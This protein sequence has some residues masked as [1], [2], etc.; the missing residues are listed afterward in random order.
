MNK[1]E[2]RVINAFINC[3]KNG[4]FT[5]DYACT[6]IEDSNKYG[7]LT[8]AAKEVFYA[9]VEKVDEAPETEEIEDTVGEFL[10]IE[11]TTAST[12]EVAEAEE[13]EDTAN[14]V[15]I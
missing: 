8:D 10:G 6:L 13:N 14:G 2:T 1:R 3:V 7:Y 9:E 4:E 12:D 5:F 11:E 15:D